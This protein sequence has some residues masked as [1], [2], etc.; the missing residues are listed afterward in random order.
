MDVQ[1][2][3]REITQGSLSTS[4]KQ[5]M[6]ELKNEIQIMVN[7]KEKSCVPHSRVSVC[8]FDRMSP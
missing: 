2:N 3:Q 7:L 4:K 6:E 8:F 5:N 1:Q